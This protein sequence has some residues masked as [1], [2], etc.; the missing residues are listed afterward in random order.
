MAT[1]E[2][3]KFWEIPSIQ[4]KLEKVITKRFTS[5]YTNKENVNRIKNY[6]IVNNRLN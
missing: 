3:I 6:K 1:N 2:G 4:T 5:A